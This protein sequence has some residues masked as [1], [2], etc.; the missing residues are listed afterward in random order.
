MNSKHKLLFLIP[1]LET[2]GSQKVLSILLNNISLEKYDISLAVL[3]HTGV[4]YDSIPKRIKKIDL[5]ISR[6]RF[7][8][9]KV[10]K[11][12]KQ[13]SPDV[14]FVFDVNNLSLIVSVLTF[15]LPEKIK[16]ITRESTIISVF[17]NRYPVFK[18]VIKVLYKYTFRRFDKIVCQAN[19]MKQD[20]VDNFGVNGDKIIVIN[21]PLETD[22]ITHLSLG[23]KKLFDSNA[24]NIIA[25]GRF[26]RAKG[27]DRLIEAFSLVKMPNIHLTIIGDATP[28]DLGCA[29]EIMNKVKFH[30]L[31]EKISF[32]GFKENPYE[33]MAQA[34]LLVMTSHYEGF[35]NVAIEANI[36][37]TPV[38]AFNCPGGIREIIDDGV[39]GCLIENNDIHQLASAIDRVSK[40]STD[41]KCITWH[42]KEKYDIA[43]IIPQ[44]E[45][46]ISELIA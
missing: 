2:G 36:L 10:Y 12:I 3:T 5:G 37:G 28:E 20:L 32:V 41:R 44:Y 40:I 24:Y 43:K 38:M 4:F 15:F 11:T 35:P 18:N 27:F 46:I 1:T 33:Y 7:S 9:Y 13:L 31:N 6:V 29:E 42:A 30:N 21:N 25:V 26:V 14:V 16:F 45:N 22:R 23:S 19:Y 8:A 17:I 34:D 39:N